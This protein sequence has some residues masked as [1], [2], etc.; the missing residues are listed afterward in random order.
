MKKAFWVFAVGTLLAWSVQAQEDDFMGFMGEDPNNPHIT[1]WGAGT[2]MESEE[3][4]AAMWVICDRLQ[5]IFD[6]TT[7]EVFSFIPEDILQSAQENGDETIIICE[8]NGQG[9]I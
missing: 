4:L 9:D 6:K 2:P 1:Y 7:G 8:D 5:P 3:V